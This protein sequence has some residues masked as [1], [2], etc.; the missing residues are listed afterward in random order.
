MNL[1]HIDSSI[2]GPASVTRQLTAQIVASLA[3]SVPGLAVVRRDLEAEPLPHLDHA[4]LSASF[5]G[6]PP[7]AQTRDQ[8]EAGAKVLDEFLKADVVVIGAPMYNFGISSQLKAWIDR[9]LI[10]GKTFKYTAQGPQGLVSGKKVIIASSRGGF[11]APGSSQ[12]VMDFQEAYLRAAFAFIGIGEVE[13]V[14]AEGIAVG[15]EQKQTAL[16]Q[17]SETVAALA[18]SF[19]PTLAA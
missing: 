11:Y 6:S 10:A 19:A 13:I 9:I 5:A 1:L 2:T 3:K 18:R 7:D 16:N 4:T 17:A 12:A 15:P 8:V 14:R